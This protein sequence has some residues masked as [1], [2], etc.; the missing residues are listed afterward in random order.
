MY[1]PERF[2][3][4]FDAYVKGVIDQAD[5]GEFYSLLRTGNYDSVLSY[6]LDTYSQVE[7]LKD[8]PALDNPDLVFDRLINQINKIDRVQDLVIQPHKVGLFRKWIFAA[9]LGCIVF[10]LLCVSKQ[11]S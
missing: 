1:T 8:E 2:I 11:I 5:L 9:A 6:C 10:F 4:L 3:S 7:S